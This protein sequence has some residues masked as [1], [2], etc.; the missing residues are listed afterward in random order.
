MR[1]TLRQKTGEDLRREYVILGACNPK[2]AGRALASETEIGLYLPCNVVV[3]E[4]DDSVVGATRSQTISS[5]SA[6]SSYRK[7]S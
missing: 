7:S 5:S 4:A 2:L 6:S 3:Y 1:E